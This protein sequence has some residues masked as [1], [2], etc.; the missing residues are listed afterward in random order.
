MTK[1][2]SGSGIG[3][4]TELRDAL[5]R[6]AAERDWEQFHTPKNLAMALSVEAAELL[7]HFQWTADSNPGS[8]TPEARQEVGDEA[9]DVLLYLVRLADKLDIDLL[10]AAAAKIEKNAKKY[11]VDK[12]RGSSK[13]YT[14]L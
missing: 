6:F 4:F 3:S 7:E 8:L 5:R 11:P 10:G 1:E 12:A 2:T 9:A 14:E 13:K